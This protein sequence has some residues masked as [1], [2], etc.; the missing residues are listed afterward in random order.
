MTDFGMAEFI[1]LLH[2]LIV[3]LRVIFTAV[4][5]VAA[6]LAA[7]AWAERTRRINAFGALARL[8]RK[9]DPLIAPVERRIGRFGG[10]HANAPWWALLAVLLIGAA[11]LGL[12]GY[13]RDVLSS[14]YYAI[15]QGPRGIARLVVSS[16]FMVIQVAL[17]GRVIMSWIGGTYSRLGQLA[18][19][20]TEW[21]LGPLRAVLPSIGMVDISPMVAYFALSLIRG[22]VLG[23]I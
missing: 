19:R 5:V 9:L 1:L 14:I 4:L 12:V 2:V 10:T 16:L 7:L 3:W 22:V 21:F 8:A 13:L 20:L 6:A 23:A 18:Y 17:I 15:D 11:L